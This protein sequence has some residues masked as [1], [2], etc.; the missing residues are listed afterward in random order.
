MIKIILVSGF[1]VLAFLITMLTLVA[2]DQQKQI[3]KPR[4]IKLLKNEY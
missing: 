1:I 2:I 4:K 3:K